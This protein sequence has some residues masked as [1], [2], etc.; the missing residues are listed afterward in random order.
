VQTVEG[1]LG[2]PR[3]AELAPAEMSRALEARRFSDP[4]LVV[5]A[6]PMPLVGY[7][8][9]RSLSA[10]FGVTRPVDIHPGPHRIPGYLVCVHGRSYIRPLLLASACEGS[11]AGVVL[12][13]SIPTGTPALWIAGPG[14]PATLNGADL[15]CLDNV[16]IELAGCRHQLEATVLEFNVLPD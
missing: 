16:S 6:A 10:A 2:L 5:G 3:L 12:E 1:A 14:D 9:V 7:R 15:I 13:L 11:P 4:E 8:C